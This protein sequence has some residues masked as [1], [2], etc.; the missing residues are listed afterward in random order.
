MQELRRVY[1]CALGAQS[2]SD[3]ADLAVGPRGRAPGKLVRNCAVWERESA[4]LR[5]V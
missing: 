1:V 4:R 2:R 5:V 3:L